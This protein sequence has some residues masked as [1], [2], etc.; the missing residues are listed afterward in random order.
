M[1]ESVLGRLHPD[2]TGNERAD[3]AGRP[4]CVIIGAGPAGLTAA[5]ELST[6]GYSSVVLE[7]DDTV[8]GISRTCEYKGYRFDVGGHRF[9]TKVDYV[10]TLWNEILE[11]EFLIRARLSRIYYRQKFFDYPLKPVNALLGLGPFEAVRIAGSYLRARLWPEPEEANFEQWITN[12]FGR[13]LFQIFFKTYTEKVWGIPCNEISADW[14]AQRIKNLDLWTT[15]RHAFLGSQRTG[16]GGVVTTLIDQFHYPR[17]GPG[18][19]WES[20]THRLEQR[21]MRVAMRSRVVGMRHAHGRVRSVRVSESGGNDYELEGEHFV[22]SM[23]IPALI[24]CLSPAPPP[25]VLAAAAQLRYRDFLTVAL[26]VDKPDLFPDNWIYIHSDTVRVGRIQNFKNWSPDM[27]PH[28]GHTALGLE[29]FVD[30]GDDLWSMADADLVALGRREVDTLNLAPADAVIDGTVVRMPKAYP[31]YDGQYRDALRVLRDWLGG[32]ENLQL[33]GRNGQHRYNN[34]DHSMLTAV[35]AARNIA[36]ERYD[37]WDVNVEDQY[38]E[39]RAA[40]DTG[41]GG[42]R[43]VP[44]RID[45]SI[46]EVLADVFATYDPVALGAAVGS[47]SAVLLFLATAVLLIKGGDPLGPNV[48]LLANYLLGYTVSWGGAVLGLV[49]AGLG[50]FGFGYLLATTLNWVIHQQQRELLARVAGTRSMSLFEGDES[51]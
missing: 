14:A 7:A 22:S 32:L 21:G 28:P 27:V 49:E 39:E 15:L 45:R 16:T 29:Y 31:V 9:F 4:A 1:Q 41:H 25:E 37:I 26:I 19:M 50:G 5:Y 46:Q 30:E 20:C 42:D 18:Q 35:Y 43:L 11:D 47:V 23:P 38:H 17:H 44:R 34:Q 24:R 33:I 12:R 3:A 2:P 40:G 8:G 13:R 51:S 6:L 10:R 36:G 48:S